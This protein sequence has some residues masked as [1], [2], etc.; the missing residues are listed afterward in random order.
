MYLKNC[1]LG[2]S[3]IQSLFVEALPVLPNVQSLRVNNNG[4]PPNA[5]C[6]RVHMLHAL[7]CIQSSIVDLCFRQLGRL[8][9]F[10]STTH[11]EKSWSGMRADV[12]RSIVLALSSCHNDVCLDDEAL[13]VL[14][15][16]FKKNQRCWNSELEDLSHILFPTNREDVLS[17]SVGIKEIFES[18]IVCAHI[19]FYVPYDSPVAGTAPSN[20]R[21]GSLRRSAARDLD[22]Q[23]QK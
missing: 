5:E 12:A 9:H 16:H 13:S 4:A 19:L 3:G 2:E 18:S 14:L 15:S 23:Q 6:F 10:K 1:S 21:A 8:I 22:S 7:S 11:E 20:S 17:S